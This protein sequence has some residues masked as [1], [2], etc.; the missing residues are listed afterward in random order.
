MKK[1]LL[2]ISGLLSTA[3][4]WG[5]YCTP[6]YGSQCTSGDY[7]N[8]VSFNTMS[9]LGTGCSSP[10]ASNYVDYSA[11][12]SLTTN[13]Q[14]NTA[15]T[16]SVAPGPSWGQY[17]VAYFDFNQDGD[18]DDAGEFFDVGYAASG[19]TINASI[20]IPTGIPGGP[21][22]MRVVCRYG[23]STLTA[24]DY[25]ATGL[26]FGETEDYTVMISAPLSEDASISAFTTPAI[27]TCSFT[28]SVRVELFNYG[29]NNLTSANIDWEV[30]SVAQSTVV[31][32][33]NLAP[34][35]SEIVTLGLAPLAPGDDLKAWSSMP[36]GVAEIP[37]G[38]WNDTTEI[39]GL[40][41]GLAGVYTIGATGDYLTFTDAV[42]AL[43]TN[44]V[45]SAVTFNV[46]DG[47]YNEQ[48]VLTEVIGMD[49]ANTVTFQSLNGDPLLAGITFASTLSTENYVVK[50]DGGDY[51]TFNDLSFANTGTS[52]SRALEITNGANYNSFDGNIFVGTQGLTTTSTNYAVLYSN[53]SI[54]EYNSFTN[55]T[56]D[57][58]SYGV[59]FYGVGTTSLEKGLT[60]QNNDVINA[61]YR[62]LHLYYQ[63]SVTVTGNMMELNGLYTGTNYVM[64][65]YYMN[66]V[67]TVADNYLHTTQDGYGWYA[68]QCDAPPTVKARAYNNRI[69]VEDSVSTSTSYGIYFTGSDNWIVSNN[70]INII[71]Q[72]TSS[73]ALYFS[74]GGMELYSN[75]L[76][77]DGPGYGIYYSSGLTASDNNN[78]YVPNGNVGYFSGDQATLVDWQN[79]SFLDVNSVS[80]DPGFFSST[81]LHT[82]NDT[83]LD[84]AGMVDM[85]IM[86]D[87]D[88][89]VRDTNAFDIGAD[90]FLGLVNLG[91]AQD[92]ITKC[93]QDAATLGGW[94]PMDDAT[95]LWSTTETTPTID[96]GAAGFYTVTVTTGCGTTTASVEVENIPDAVAGFTTGSSFVTGIFTNTSSGTITSYLWDFGDGTT[97][98]DSDPLHVYNATG[99]F[100]VT[101]TVTGPCGTDT[102]TQDITL[103]VADIDEN[104]L[105]SALNV[106]PNPNNGEFE[107]T[108]TL[109]NAANVSAVLV[110]A[111]GQQ[112]WNAE[113]GAVSGTASESINVTNNAAGVYFLKVTADD[114]TTV[115]KI[116]VKK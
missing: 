108:V 14:Q 16:L 37:T 96:A 34:F 59:Y 19:T 72:G 57:G 1:S 23:S 8:S 21:T 81:D 4:G 88:G 115:R 100:T 114:V 62:A 18:F 86:Y 43:N 97:S 98:T 42:N 76:R 7:I 26:S 63:D 45:C 33:G 44:G 28:D 84:G 89:Q 39:N 60:F 51:Y 90:E 17:F 106:F 25:C 79:S 52:Y 24:A 65:S 91:F 109:D 22:R 107:L 93:S 64:Y 9:N 13:V 70:S 2:L 30:N 66:G 74:G 32:T 105:G 99:T 46:Q 38:A 95:Y 101:L 111:R 103:E 58:G 77:N 15:Y 83:L 41:A 50:I 27:P 10:S 69:I 35:T 55:N 12:P 102:F 53:N 40:N 87:M 67:S 110:D 20:L 3:I 92:T 116:V 73:R 6:T 36:N 48:I 68:S 47:L 82:C 85:A 104:D 56:I 94:E 80:G 75:N 112:V 11:N 31:W 113:M 49:S 61:A 78:I 5:Q 71:S 54:D 29:T